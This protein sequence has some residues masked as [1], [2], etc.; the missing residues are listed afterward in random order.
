MASSVRRLLFLAAL[1]L[2]GC[3]DGPAENPGPVAITKH[4][5]CHVC[6]MIIERFPGPKGEAYT[7]GRDRPLK[8]CS[9]RD[10]FAYL[11]QPEAQ[12]IT[13]TVYVHDMAGA[14]WTHPPDAALVDAREAWYVAGHPLRGAMGATL[15][16]FARHEDA[17]AFARRYGGRVLP[18][19]EITLEV[20]NNLGRED[21]PPPQ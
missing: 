3:G 15:A 10:L 14:D 17:A 1:A 16:S 13:R 6:G 20:I 8:F 21:D 12:T 11:L 2:G 18:F 4:D 5:E 19:D 9:T 7:E